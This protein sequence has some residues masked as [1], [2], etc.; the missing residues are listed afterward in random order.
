[1]LPQQVL[2]DTLNVLKPSELVLCNSHCPSPAYPRQTAG[3]RSLE[4]Q[5]K[6]KEGHTQS[7]Q[8]QRQ[9]GRGWL[10]SPS[11]S[12][13]RQTPVPGRPAFTRP[14]A[15]SSPY[16]PVPCS[17]H[18]PFLESLSMSHLAFQR[19]KSCQH[20]YCIKPQLPTMSELTCR[21]PVLQPKHVFRKVGR[22]LHHSL[23]EKCK[24]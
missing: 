20:H 22:V 10:P 12:P 2:T 18:T 21:R 13:R 6:D 15:A 16:S 8:K 9:P 24:T 3:M 5:S 23:L 4:H 19:S 14:L 7:E 17:P 11:A 1:M